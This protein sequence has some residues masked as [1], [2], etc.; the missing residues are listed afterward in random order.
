MLDSYEEERL[1][2]ARRLLN[3]T[4]RAFILWCRIAGSPACCARKDAR[5]D[6][7]VC[8]RVSNASRRSHFASFPDRYRIP[9]ELVVGIP[10]GP[11]R[12]RAAR[13]RSFSMAA[14]QAT[15]ERP[16]EDM[17][18]KLDDTRFNLIVIGQPSP[19]EE[20]LGPGDMLGIPP[21]QPMPSTTWNVTSANTPTFILSR[22]S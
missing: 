16:V 22:A 9:Q 5:Q 10:G 1:P 11:A 2:V 15:G 17:F 20:A 4:D 21:F 19:S 12:Q 8:D 3:T 7:G 14:A 13:R 18:R 6:R